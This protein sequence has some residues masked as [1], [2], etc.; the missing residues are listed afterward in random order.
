MGDD[1]F[2]PFTTHYNAKDA[3]RAD[4]M[5]R[6]LVRRRLAGGSGIGIKQG[7]LGGALNSYRVL[8]EKAAERAWI[9]KQRPDASFAKKADELLAFVEQA[10]GKDPALS[11]DSK[12]YA[13]VVDAYAKVGDP[14]SAEAVL[15][16]LEKLW[17]SGN[18][19]VQPDT[20]LYSTVREEERR[21]GEQKP[22]YNTWNS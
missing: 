6:D 15:L 11:P 5:V 16:R 3:D 14:E 18:E 21:R 8:S 9:R 13:M 22:Y 19:K 2:D 17:R 1:G 12:F 20:I 4:R 7:F 10:Y